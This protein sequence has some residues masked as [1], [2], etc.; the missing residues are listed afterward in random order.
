[1]IVQL[2]TVTWPLD[3]EHVR[4]VRD[5]TDFIMDQK[6]L[7][8]TSTF[9]KSNKEVFLGITDVGYNFV[10]QGFEFT[11]PVLGVAFL[12]A[13]EK[14]FM[15]CNVL[16]NFPINQGVLDLIGTS[17]DGMD[18]CPEGFRPFPPN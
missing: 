3:R 1:M 15:F 12:I 14:Q 9:G 6:L 2:A 13:P 5:L 17:L 10:S 4:W 18:N 8:I 16:A 11:E 7:R